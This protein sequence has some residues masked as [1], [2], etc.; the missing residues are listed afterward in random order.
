MTPESLTYEQCPFNRERV[1][2]LYRNIRNLDESGE[3]VAIDVRNGIGFYRVFRGRTF[4]ALFSG[5]PS[6]LLTEVFELEPPDT[7][8]DSAW[9]IKR[10]EGYF[11]ISSKFT[12]T[13]G[14]FPG[15]ESVNESLEAFGLYLDPQHRYLEGVALLPE[16]TTPLL[17]EAMT[18]LRWLETA[19][20]MANR[21]AG[22]T[23]QQEWTKIQQLC[24]ARIAEYPESE[25]VLP[26][27][28][29]LPLSG[30]KSREPI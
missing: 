17:D 23:L 8:E 14:P 22:A 11:S 26:L 21:A 3:W 10:D 18:R 4:Q 13:Y 29:G 9:K 1:L 7:A 16:L 20:L 19:C 15:V 2:A 24:E 28:P 27:P 6:N 30:P 25:E 12:T 5:G